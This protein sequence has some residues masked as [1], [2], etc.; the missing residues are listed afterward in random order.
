MLGVP[1]LP[2]RPPVLPLP[3]GLRPASSAVRRG[4]NGP[5]G[6]CW[7]PGLLRTGF[8]AGVVELVD[9]SDV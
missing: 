7:W 4:D 5:T 8:V 1:S 2:S 3:I 6:S 9:E